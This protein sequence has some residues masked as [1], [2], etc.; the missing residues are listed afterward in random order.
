MRKILKNN[1]KS[2]RMSGYAKGRVGMELNISDK[3]NIKLKIGDDIS[4]GKYTG[5]LLYNPSYDQ[6]GIAL[7]YSLK[8]GADKYD[9]NSYYKF[10]EIPMDNGARMDIEKIVV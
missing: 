10:I 6:Y 9:I 5:V 7:D 3:N 4:Y 8:R 1:N 2:K